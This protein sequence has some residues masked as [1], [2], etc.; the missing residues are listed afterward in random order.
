MARKGLTPKQKRFV[1]EYL[2]DLN[3]TQA[4]IRAGYSEKTAR[5]IGQENLTKPVIIAEIQQKQSKLEEKTEITQERI[6]QELAC[7]AFAKMEDYVEIQD[8]GSCRAR[9]WA[10]MP[11]GASRA[12]A[13]V[14][15]I[16]RIM[17]S[18]E[19]GKEIV[20]ECRLGYKHHSK[21]RALELL[22]RHLGMFIDR[23]QEIPYDVETFNLPKLALPVGDNGGNGNGGQSD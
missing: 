19:G 16:R 21:E 13:E 18:G 5:S 11:E 6:L 17:G 23:V 4:A 7:L 12:V 20:L 1:Q 14:K 22:G 15:E 8:D 2:I 9:T 10:E 3:A